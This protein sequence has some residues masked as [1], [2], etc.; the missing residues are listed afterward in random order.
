MIVAYTFCNNKKC[1]IRNHD[2]FEDRNVTCIE[3]VC[4]N[5]SESIFCM[6][7]HFLPSPSN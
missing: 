5:E 2:I 3:I 4:R 7:E 6:Y 1:V